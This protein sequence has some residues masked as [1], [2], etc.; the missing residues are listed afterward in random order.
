MN[1]EH[2]LML[3]NDPL[4]ARLTRRAARSST[5]LAIGLA[6][7]LMLISFFVIRQA[8]LPFG[9]TVQA[10][11]SGRVWGGSF[12]LLS[13]GLLI[14]AGEHHWP[15]AA[16][17]L[18]LMIAWPVALL[19]PFASAYVAARLTARDMRSGQLELVRLT[20]L[21]IN[22]LIGGYLIAALIRLRMLL[23][24]LIGFIPVLVTSL[25]NIWVTRTSLWIIHSGTLYR[26]DFASWMIPDVN[27]LL[28]ILALT[29]IL[30]GWLGVVG[31]VT[32]LGVGLVLHWRKVA[33][34]VVAA[35]TVVL[36]YIVATALII[37]RLLFDP[38]LPPQYGVGL[39]LLATPFG[40]LIAATRLVRQWI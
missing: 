2:K 21:P 1:L 27:R 36:I 11:G 29:G 33:A 8:A 15:S 40:G 9:P 19:T 22:K 5:H 12:P 37:T 20:N 31:L 13:F 10:L 17:F 26:V 3:S 34:P 32:A 18:M 4:V 38:L 24:L 25:Y 28:L 30:V 39:L 7:G 35:S 6:A 23:A 16:L 14:D